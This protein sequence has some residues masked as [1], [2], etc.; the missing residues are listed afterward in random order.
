MSTRT[1]DRTNQRSGS[2]YRGS[3]FVSVCDLSDSV[4]AKSERAHLSP[5]SRRLLDQLMGALMVLADPEK[6]HTDSVQDRP[7][8]P[9]SRLQGGLTLSLYEAMHAKLSSTVNL[10]F[11]RS[12]R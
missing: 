12:R 3:Q 4:E 7:S 1:L 10:A 5:P 11:S 9:S 2:Q 6:V 8:Q